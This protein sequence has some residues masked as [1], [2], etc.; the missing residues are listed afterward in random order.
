MAGMGCGGSK[1]TQLSHN[2]AMGLQ[3]GGK[4]RHTTFIREQSAAL[5]GIM[6]GLA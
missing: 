3:M 1:S 5:M 6:D 4:T 2:E